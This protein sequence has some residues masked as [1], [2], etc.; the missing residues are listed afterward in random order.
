LGTAWHFASSKDLKRQRASSVER[1]AEI[2]VVVRACLR[3]PL[4]GYGSNYAS[5]DLTDELVQST[6]DGM[7]QRKGWRVETP[8]FKGHSAIVQSWFEG[9]LLGTVMFLI[10]LKA[11]IGA[12]RAATSEKYINAADPLLLVGVLLCGWDLLMSPFSG[13]HRAGNAVFFGAVIV[14]H[15]KYVATVRRTAYQAPPTRV[16]KRAVITA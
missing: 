4:I 8:Y 11:M 9:G 5:S 15:L 13:F 3:S 7:Q 2:G 10:M 16:G 6:A 1:S 12:L 14:S